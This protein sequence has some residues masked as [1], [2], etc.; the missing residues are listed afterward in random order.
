MKK[1]KIIGIIVGVFGSIA[2]IALG[3]GGNYLYNLAIDP[4]VSKDA[5]FNPEINESASFVDQN[6]TSGS[7]TLS[8]KEWVLNHKSLEHLYITS[9]DGLN[10]HNY[11]LT[12]P[13]SNKWVITVHGYG[14]EGIK[15]SSYSQNF[16]NMGYNVIMPDLRGHGNSEGD[17]IGMGWDERLDII[18][19]INHIVELDPDSEIVLFGVSMGA[20][21]VMNTSG[22]ILPS[23]VKAIIEDCG[24]TSTWD[25]FAIS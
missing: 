3:I 22:E 8:D 17:Y 6:S 15:M 9:N 10:L 23:N 12:Q 4:N 24:Y 2:I 18:D 11:V 25:E 7:T 14:S 19:I 1:R 20:A 5:I 13:D 21:T 16:Y